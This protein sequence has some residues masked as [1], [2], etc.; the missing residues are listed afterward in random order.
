MAWFKTASRHKSEW[1]QTSD[2]ASVV[3]RSRWVFLRDGLLIGLVLG[4]LV[5]LF[6]RW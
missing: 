6:N 4:A 3:W 5:G 2:S 1:I